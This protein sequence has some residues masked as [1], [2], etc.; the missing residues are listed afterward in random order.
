MSTFTGKHRLNQWLSRPLALNPIIFA[1][2]CNK[3]CFLNN[4]E[5]NE[6][7]F[8]LNIEQNNTLNFYKSPS[9][10]EAPN[11]ALGI[12]I[13]PEDPSL[14]MNL[15]CLCVQQPLARAS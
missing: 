5:I 2:I 12:G 6:S 10:D 7:I 15:T 14:R 9:A 3:Y 8:T 13:I 4:E 1:T 11:P